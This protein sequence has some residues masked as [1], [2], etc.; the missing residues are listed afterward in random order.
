MAA[1][2]PGLAPGGS[3]RPGRLTCGYAKLSAPVDS[4]P[5]YAWPRGVTVA[6]LHALPDEG[7]RYEL[8]DGSLIVSPS[9]TTSHNLMVSPCSVLRDTET[10]RAFYAR[11]GVPSDRIIVAKKGD[12]TISLAELVLD[13]GAAEYRYATHYTTDVVR[14]ECPWPVEIDLPALTERRARLLRRASPTD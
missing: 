7:P 10:K 14:T 5:A 13:E 1:P 11:T 2:R 9:A 12:P 3:R 6:D 4:V 8:I